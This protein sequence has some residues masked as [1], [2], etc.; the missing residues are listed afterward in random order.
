MA[1]AIQRIHG[2]NSYDAT[3]TYPR[4]SQI[5]QIQDDFML[6]QLLFLLPPPAHQPAGGLL[7]LLLPSAL[8]MTSQCQRSEPELLLLLS[9]LSQV[10]AILA[11]T[12]I[13]VATAIATST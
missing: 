3:V 4:P 8:S 11:F 6:P 5:F 7:V 9:L 10:T 1:T 12:A 2:N 13:L